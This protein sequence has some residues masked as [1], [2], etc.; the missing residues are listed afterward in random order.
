MKKLIYLSFATL[1]MLF[2]TVSCSDDDDD[3]LP[4]AP[5]ANTE[6]K[7]VIEKLE[8]MDGFTE[9]TKVLKETDGI[10]VG[11]DVITVFAVKDA[12]TPE[13]ETAEE[14]ISKENIK[15]HIV[16]GTYDLTK[17]ISDSLVVKGID[18]KPIAITQKDGKVYIND[19]LMEGAA[20]EV[21]KNLIYG[22]EKV[23]PVV[24]IKEYTANFTVYEANEE[25]AEGAKEKDLSKEAMIRFYTYFNDNFRCIDSVATNEEG[26]AVYKH[27]RYQNLFYTVDK[28]AKTQLRDNYLVIGLFTTQEQ[29][30]KAPEYKT[31][32]NLDDLKLGSLMISDIDGDGTINEKDKVESPYME[33]DNSAKN[34]DLFIVSADYMKEESAS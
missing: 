9:F 3:P 34:T 18:D 19:V 29:L 5:P 20:T 28:G 12:T 10:D 33:V 26:K 27:F 8:G 15:H 13:K 30:D 16:K 17:L 24:D 23:I 6:L 14:G 21:E 4:P 22:V 7:K 1:A 11:D 32:T 2:S 31:G 25:W